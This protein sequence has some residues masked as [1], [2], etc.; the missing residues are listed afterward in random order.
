MRCRPSAQPNS[1]GCRWFWV[2]LF[3]WSCCLG[4]VVAPR[5][6]PSRARD[7]VAIRAGPVGATTGA[8][9]AAL[10]DQLDIF[11]RE[12]T[13][14]ESLEDLA[15][16]DLPLLST[17][18]REFGFKLFETHRPGSDLRDT[19]L[20]VQDRFGFCRPALVASWRVVRTWERLD[21]SEARTPLPHSVL[22]ACKA[23]AL[24][25]NWPRVALLLHLGFFCL[26]RPGE[27]FALRR[28]DIL[29]NTTA[30]GVDW[31]I[32]IAKSKSWSRSAKSQYAKL[33]AAQSC[34]FCVHF[35]GNMSPSVR[36][37]PASP[38]AFAAR[39][40]AVVKA[41]T[42]RPVPFTPGSLR[43]GGATWL[44]LEWRED[45][46]RLCWRGRWK[47]IQTLWHYIQELQSVGILQQYPAQTQARIDSLVACLA[48]VIEEWVSTDGESLGL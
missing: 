7:S 1:G 17:L 8:R 11:I 39:L 19:L 35:V 43:T 26:L 13:A 45:L 47:D 34:E 2:L 31:L 41:A 33:D 23:I 10:V 25:W 36:L 40:Q 37:W 44:F 28:G 38:S 48:A 9:R 46:P 5:P 27:L 14:T 42:S 22:L 21:P 16:R 4:D 32:R 29:L 3:G 24:A 18:A 20:G 6:P 30:A 12:Q 15:L